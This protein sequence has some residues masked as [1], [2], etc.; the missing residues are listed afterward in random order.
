MTTNVTLRRM[1]VNV[2]EG[3]NDTVD[4]EG[5]L[6]GS[7][8][9]TGTPLVVEVNTTDLSITNK[10]VNTVEQTVEGRT[11][12]IGEGIDYTISGFVKGIYRLKITLI[13]TATPVATRIGFAEYEVCG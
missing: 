11:V 3:F 4:I 1:P 8:L 10:A 2:G 13:T 12:A 7:E 9:A 6:K 5:L